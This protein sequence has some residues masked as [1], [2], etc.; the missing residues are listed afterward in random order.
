LDLEQ[1]DVSI[2]I[3]L[4]AR[5]SLSRDRPPRASYNRIASVEKTVVWSRIL[6]RTGQP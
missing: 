6:A 4:R 3:P 2:V 1:I 5:I